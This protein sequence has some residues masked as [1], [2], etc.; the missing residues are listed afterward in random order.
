M[1]SVDCAMTSYDPIT[2]NAAVARMSGSSIMVQ[3]VAIS[4]VLN[5][6]R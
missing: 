6:M 1:M 2:L 5:F 4:R 3:N